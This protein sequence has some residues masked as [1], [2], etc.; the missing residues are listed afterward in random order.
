MF[1]KVHSVSYRL[2]LPRF[3][4]VQTGSAPGTVSS[5][6]GLSRG[7]GHFSLHCRQERAF[8]A[9]GIN[10]RSAPI[11]QADSLLSAWGGSNGMA[12]NASSWH[13]SDSHGHFMILGLTF[14][15]CGHRRSR[16]RVHGR[17]AV[18]LPDVRF[19]GASQRATDGGASGEPFHPP[20]PHPPFSFLLPTQ[21]PFCPSLSTPL[22]RCPL[23]T[24]IAA[25]CTYS[26]QQGPDVSARVSVPGYCPPNSLHHTGFIL[27]ADFKLM[28]G[29]T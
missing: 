24:P 9:T 21:P 25:S 15:K 5:P 6:A 26:E 4:F 13:H 17:G 10:P 8:G 19:Y 2:T 23:G 1:E 16:E 22:C 28:I 11:H 20:P 7:R 27:C 3:G 14:V 12:P 18:H 29:S